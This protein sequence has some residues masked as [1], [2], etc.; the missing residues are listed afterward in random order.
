MNDG[1]PEPKSTGA[2]G[3]LAEYRAGRLTLDDLAGKWAGQRFAEPDMAATP[4]VAAEVWDRADERER[5]QPGTWQEVRDMYLD[6]RLTKEEYATVSKAVDVAHHPESDTAA[7]SN[8]PDT[9]PLPDV[10]AAAPETK[11]KDAPP[12]IDRGSFV[13]WSGGKGR[14]DLIVT[15][16]KVPDAPGD[17]EGTP[18]SPAARCV[19]WEKDGEDW[20]AGTNKYAAKVQTLKR[21]PPLT[22]SGKSL[23]GLDALVGLL[24]DHEQ[25]IEAK[26]LPDS[27][28]VTG[29]AVKTV[30][31][32]GMEGWPGDEVTSLTREQWA[33]GRVKAFLETAAGDDLAPMN[34][35]DTDMLSQIHPARGLQGK[36]HEIDLDADLAD[37]DLS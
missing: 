14:V 7:A 26:N 24:A 18:P 27:A 2:A 37:L 1:Q 12:S 15:N 28:R 3:D 25:E 29:L 9:A 8:R 19:V 34:P 35:D 13:S 33:V 23:G 11:G 4:T 36:T 21:I 30:A 20:K 17:V 31:D 32:R 6:G 16:G 22:K 5:S 10:P